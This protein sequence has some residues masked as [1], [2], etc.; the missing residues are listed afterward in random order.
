[1][2]RMLAERLLHEGKNDT[3]RLDLLFTWLAC[4][5]AADRER[6][7]CVALLEAMRSRYAGAEDDALALL[8]SGDAPRDEKLNAAEH[9]AWTQLGVTVLASDVAIMLY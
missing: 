1:M 6:T 9:A 3:D 7:A 2:A 8:A 5:K 4:R